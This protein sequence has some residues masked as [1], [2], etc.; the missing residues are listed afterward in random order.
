MQSEW[1][2]ALHMTVTGGSHEPELGVVLT[3]LPK[4]T[5]VDCEAL[6]S[7]LARRAPGLGV[8]STARKEPDRVRIL[9]GLSGGVTDGSPLSAVIENRN[10][11]SAPYETYRRVPRP[12]QI[13]LPARWR[14]GD[15]V[16]LRGGGHFSGRMTAAYCIAGGIAMQALSRLG[17]QVA[18]HL[19]SVGAVSDAVFDPV[20]P[21]PDLLSTLS[22]KP[23]PVLDDDAGLAMQREIEAAKAEGDSIGGVIECIV[24]GFPKG[25]GT[26]LFNGV[27]SRLSALLFA[28]P[29]VRAVAFGSGFSA[30]QM[31]GSAHN[32]PYVLQNGEIRT[33]SNRHGGIIG[34]I[35]TGMPIVF[36]AAVKPAASIGLAQQTLDL[37]TGEQTVLRIEGRHD[38]CIAVRAVPVIEAAA[39]LALYDLYLEETKC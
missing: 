22:Q 14:F 8:G 17:V 4:G 34:G 31:R 19:L 24:T 15:D 38:A 5:P 16:D 3:G 32:D 6:Q 18:A 25:F 20:D 26:P 36:T 13:D 33:V 27:D 12:S 2:H 9:S 21:D 35:T 37:H 7:F 29:A 23:F 1:G 11:D 30:A 28:V 10:F 39:A